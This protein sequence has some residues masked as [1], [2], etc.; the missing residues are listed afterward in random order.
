MYLDILEERMNQ[1]NQRG[2]SNAHSLSSGTD[3]EW[4]DP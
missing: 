2:A 1:V 3:F 4:D